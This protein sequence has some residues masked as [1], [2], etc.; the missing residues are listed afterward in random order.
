MINPIPRTLVVASAITGTLIGLAA[1]SSGPKMVSKDDIAKQ[2]TAKMSDAA[3]NKPDSVSC[4][5]GLKGEVGAQLNCAMKIK[6]QDYNV[7]VTATS[8]KGDDVEFDMVETVDKDLVASK[9]SEQL[10]QK[11]GRKPDA[12]TCPDNLKGAVGSTLR[13]DLK[14]DGQTYGVTVTVSD[15]EAGDVHF[16]FKVDDQAK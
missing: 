10:T 16:D 14:D 3:G 6:G 1:C 7:N 15:V 12:V 5:D 9:V 8:V 4:P 11:V 2:I 13:C